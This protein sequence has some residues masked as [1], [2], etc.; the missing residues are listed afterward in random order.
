MQIYLRDEMIKIL[1]YFLATQ[2]LIQQLRLKLLREI[3]VQ[4]VFPK[5]KTNLEI[6]MMEFQSIRKELR[7]LVMLP[8]KKK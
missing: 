7:W 6:P 4:K 5:R 1:S 3:V 2:L 8:C